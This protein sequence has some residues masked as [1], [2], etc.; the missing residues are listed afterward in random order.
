M[1][2]KTGVGSD[3]VVSLE[4]PPDGE[5]ADEGE[6]DAAVVAVGLSSTDDPATDGSGVDAWF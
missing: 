5:G 4:T 1:I 2:R 3:P 6:D